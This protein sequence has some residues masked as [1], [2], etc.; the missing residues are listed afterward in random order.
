MSKLNLVSMQ[1]PGSVMAAASFEGM[2]GLK[3]DGV[4][5]FWGRA[6]DWLIAVQKRRAESA[7]KRYYDEF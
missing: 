7:L 4:Q 5:G 3:L 6:F 1:V 2:H